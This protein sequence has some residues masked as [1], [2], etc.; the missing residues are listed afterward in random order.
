MFAVRTKSTGNPSAIR[1]ARRWRSP[2]ALDIA[3]GVVGLN[4]KLSVVH[5]F[6]LPYTSGV[7]KLTKFLTPPH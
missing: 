4:V 7:E 6:V 1:T 3:Y 2:A 5:S